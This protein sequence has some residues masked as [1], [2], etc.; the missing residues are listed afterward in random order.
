MLTPRLRSPLWIAAG[1][2]AVGV[3]LLVQA[4]D[5]L[6]AVRLWR[7]DVGVYADVAR[8]FLTEG[9]WP[10][11]EYPPGA[12]F[13][14]L[15]PEGMSRIVGVPNLVGLWAVN[16]LLLA[17]HVLLLA[18]LG[19]ARAGWAS[20]FLFLAAGPISLF[21]FELAASLLT[22]GAFA[23]AWKNRRLLGGV[24]LGLGAGVKLYPLVLLPV[25]LRRGG[26]GRTLTGVLLG[27][28]GLLGGYVVTGGT[29]DHLAG[30]AA[31]H[32]GK[33]V[34]IQSTWGAA[35]IMLGLLGGPW[36]AAIER[37][38]IHGVDLPSAVRWGSAVA[39]GL[40]VSSLVIASLR[41]DA[42]RDHRDDTVRVHAVLSALL[43]LQPALQPQ[44][45]LWLLPFSALVCGIRGITTARAWSIVALHALVLLGHQLL[46]PVGFAPLLLALH[47]QVASPATLW[48][49]V[50][51]GGVLLALAGLSVSTAWTLT[52]R[53]DHNDM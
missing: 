13:F 2:V 25:L 37:G 12:L 29:M 31:Y 15:L 16:G 17:F 46:Y 33:P 10:A 30:V 1:T 20:L 3:A 23:A 22:L 43:V 41:R 35:S 42:T 11:S 4:N 26:W 53:R 24:L 39:L 6:W 18:R 28:G 7:D 5:P 45:L 19:G 48:L 32:V 36:P 27:L 8:R 34:S 9:A 49:T 47:R 40:A 51:T 44:Y 21:R 38:G 52:R 50:A 14:F